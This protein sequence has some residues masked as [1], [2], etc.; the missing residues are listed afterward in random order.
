LADRLG[1]DPQHGGQGGTWETAP[2]YLLRDRDAVYGAWFQ[3]HVMNLGTDQILT[4][5]RS[6]W[7]NAYA[8]RMISGVSGGSVWIT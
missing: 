5:P 8:E 4:A 2:K 1:T 7:Q 3:R 6:P